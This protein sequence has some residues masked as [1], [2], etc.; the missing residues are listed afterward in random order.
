MRIAFLYRKHNKQHIPL[1]LM[2]RESSKEIIKEGI[3]PR[4]VRV[5]I[6]NLIRTLLILAFIGAYFNG[7]KLV[8]L[9]SVFALFVTFLPI[10]FRKTF[11]VEL[12][13]QFEVIALLFIY[14]TLFFGKAQGF[15]AQFWWWGIL[16]STGS[17]IVLGFI[18][19]AVMHT[20]YKGDKIHGSPFVIAFFSFCFAVAVGAVWELFE[21]ALDALWGFSLQQASN[22]IIDL[23]A[24]M[25]GAFFVSAVG[26]YYIKDGK[27]IIISSLISRFVEGNPRIFGVNV[28]DHSKKI[29]NLI[30]EGEGD[31]VEFKST[32]RTN[33]HTS[34]TDKKMEH[35]VLKTIAAYLNSNGGT[36]LVGVS[37]DGEILGMEKDGFPDKD[38]LNLH[39]TNLI[40]ASIG[41]EYLPFIN[42]DLITIDGKS[43]LKIECLQSNKH[44]FLKAGNGEEF[45]VRN[46]PSSVRLDGSSLVDYINNKFLDNRRV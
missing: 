33:L 25:A 11:D 21:S 6:I 20:L 12:P 22:I 15:Y 8:L 23:T 40:K 1:N 46:G 42:H 39:F 34:L 35:A 14:G 10:V 32:L 24:N 17:A 38:K 19:L 30:N 44:V 9:I 26:Y 28:E 43:V 36:L 41:S 2:K 4:K 31:K 37:N 18:G 7:R 29:I 27:V 13:A 45:Y 3:Q 5:I 16:F